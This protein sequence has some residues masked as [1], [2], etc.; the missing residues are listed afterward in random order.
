MQDKETHKE[1][2]EEENQKKDKT[3][4]LKVS[5]NYNCSESGTY[6]NYCSNFNVY[7]CFF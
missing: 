4:V 5:I 3:V 6:Y 1:K 7:D 2:G